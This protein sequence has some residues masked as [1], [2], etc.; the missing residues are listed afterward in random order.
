M[1]L[2]IPNSSYERIVILGAGFA[3]YTLARK[4]AGKK[5]QIVLVD[6]N[7][8]HQFQPL[9]YQVGMSGLEPSSICF[10]L[11]RSFQSNPDFFVRVTEVNSIDVQSKM[12]HTSSGAIRYDK[13]VLALGAKTN[14]F[15][16]TD[17]EKNS[18]PLKSVSEALYLRNKL[19]NDL[20]SALLLKADQDISTFLEI[21]IVGGGPTGVELAGALAEM[22]NNILPKD[23]PDLDATKMNIHL[24]QHAE[25]LLPSMS[26][27]SAQ[28]AKSYLENM[29]VKV[30]LGVKVT[31]IKNQLVH[32]NTGQT[33]ASNK[34]IWAAGITPVS[35]QGLP[36]HVYSRDH[37]ILVNSY[38]KV[39]GTEDIFAIGDIADLNS[40][41]DHSSL[42][43]VAQVALQQ[44]SWLSKFLVNH[45]QHPF[46]YHDKGQMAT[47][48]RNKAVVD[49]GKFHFSGFF[50]WLV[51]LFI[52]IYYLIGVRNKIIVL[53]NWIWA[54]F[55]YDQSLRLLIKPFRA[56][57]LNS[58]QSNLT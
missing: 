46:H 11:R 35:I 58:D 15:G 19:L 47:I 56:Y 52:H 21:V 27:K 4:L 53:L 10:P 25:R 41:A 29:G 49:I 13:L 48:G 42:P 43:Q 39:Y 8:F 51:W 14:Y 37:R 54:Y 28:K 23:Y 6:R 2:N 7:N 55:S 20:E 44:A 17:F 9:F 16:N 40:D 34:V 32:L 22:K 50:A 57:N 38:L 26:L 31:S 45:A 24:I 33:I 1:P 30:H 5:F 36:E 3:G 18:I 12:I